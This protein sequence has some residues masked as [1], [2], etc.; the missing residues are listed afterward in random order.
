M[1]P[2]ARASDNFFG[3]RFFFHSFLYTGLQTL[4]N[5]WEK[6]DLFII[7]HFSE[8]SKHSLTLRYPA[9]V[10]KRAVYRTRPLRLERQA[11]PNHK[12]FFLV[13]VLFHYLLHTAA[14]ARASAYFLGR[15]YVLFSPFPAHGC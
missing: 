6:K 13:Y 11:K 1:A 4:L 2:K 5:A 15:V 7:K 8:V 14:K 10:S 12:Q 3:Y 9:C